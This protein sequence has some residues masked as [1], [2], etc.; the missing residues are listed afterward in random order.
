[1]IIVVVI[2]LSLLLGLID[3]LLKTIVLDWLLKL[4]H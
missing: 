3:W 1:V 2:I 4:G